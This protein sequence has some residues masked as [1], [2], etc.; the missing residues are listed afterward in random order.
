MGIRTPDIL[1]AKQA[2]YQLSYVP[3][4]SDSWRSSCG[5]PAARRGSLAVIEN[6]A[7]VLTDQ[8]TPFAYPAARRSEQLDD[9]HG[10]TVAD[11][12][13]WLEDVDSPE[14]TAWIEAENTVT[15]AFLAEIPQ[16][17]AVRDRLNAIWNY[18]RFSVPSREGTLYAYFKNSGLQNQAVLY[19]CE[20]IGESERVLLDPN[21]LSDD[22]TVALSGASFSRDGQ[23]FAYATSASGSDWLEWRVRE[24]ASGVDRPDIVRWSK[25]SNAAWTRD[26]SGFYYSRYA[27]PTSDAQFK[28][29][30]YYH[31]LYFHRLGTAQEEDALIYERA[32]HKDWNFA[33]AVSDD[34]R[35]LV[36]DVGEG[37]DPKNRIFVCDLDTPAPKVIELLD[38]ADAMYHFLGNDGDQ[39]IFRTTRDAPRGRVVRIGMTDRTPHEIVPETADTLQDAT[40][41]GER[42]ITNYLHDA[43]ALVRVFDGAGSLGRDIELPGLGSVGG[44]HGRRTSTETFFS[45]TSYTAPT[46]IYRYEIASGTTT[47]VFAPRVGFDTSLYTSEQLFYTSKDGTRVPMIISHKKGLVRDGSAPTIL[48]GYGGFDVSLTPAFSPAMLVWM[49]MGGAY[50]VAN[51]RGGG[52]YGEAWHLA[53]TGAFKHNVFDDFIAGAEYLI[54]ERWTST[55]KLAIAGGSNGG[56]L[57]GAC[58]TQRP[59]LFGAALPAVG[60]MDMLRYQHFTIGWAWASDYGLSDDPEAFEALYAYSPLHRLRSGTAYPATLV[61]TADH[62]D[63]VFPAHSFKFA[64]E[65]QHDQAGAAPALIR[66]ESKAG[67]GAGKPMSKIIDEAADRYA[68]L[69]RV[70]DM[71]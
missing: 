6:G 66:I 48:Y 23:L 30:N 44:F 36:I 3:G 45:Y 1:L 41:F 34:G 16:R 67:H 53:G 68:F 33:S 25:F 49:E 19:V 15:E 17:G 57:V 62:D 35:W 39:F 71:A 70:L 63:R 14:T 42:I 2:L 29:A 7:G 27:E 12:Y 69:V 40:L 43:H 21:T 38:T 18:E 24:V 64:A 20:G 51:L 32:D 65:L 4:A 50:A 59:D 56:L 31:R 37:T 5:V 58:M 55:P 52:E 60:V 11:P 47:Q 9:Y 61:T 13:R 54:D 22:G 10:T 28:D 8:S 46:T 26:G